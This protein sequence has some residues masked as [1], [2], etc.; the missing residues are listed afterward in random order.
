MVRALNYDA[1]VPEGIVSGQISVTAAKTPPGDYK[2]K[3]FVP[4]TKV[5]PI[6]P[7]ATEQRKKF[8]RAPTARYEQDYIP[9]EESANRRKKEK[10]AILE[11]AKQLY[12]QETRVREMFA[13]AQKLVAKATKNELA[14]PDKELLRAQKVLARYKPI[15]KQEAIEK[16]TEQFYGVSTRA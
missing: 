16:A 9:P 3:D 5:A 11:L 15:T 12:S 6:K 13:A 10:G 2:Y 7:S 1:S 4:A 8:M 14:K